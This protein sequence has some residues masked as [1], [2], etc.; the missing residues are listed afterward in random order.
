MGF[1]FQEAGPIF[2]TTLDR[3][4]RR[5]G[6]REVLMETNAKRI[7]LAEDNRVMGDVMRFNLERCKYDVTWVTNGKAALELL[8]EQE[9]DILLTDYQMPGLN[10]Q[11]L[12]AGFKEL[13]RDRKIPIVMISARGLELDVDRLREDL[14]IVQVLYKPFSPRTLVELVQMLLAPATA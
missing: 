8:K 12:C 3:D 1:G 14:E 2:C 4:P 5:P 10:G 9:F 7:L 13:D 11:E 6:E